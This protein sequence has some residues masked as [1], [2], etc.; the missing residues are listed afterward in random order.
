MWQVEMWLSENANSYLQ[1]G[2]T[3]T[4]EVIFVIL[5]VR[6]YVIFA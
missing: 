3:D 5:V 1:L 6:F 2:V 4:L